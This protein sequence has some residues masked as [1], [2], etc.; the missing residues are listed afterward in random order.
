MSGYWL[1]RTECP[2]REPAPKREVTEV[3]LT[4]RQAAEGLRVPK[5]GL[6]LPSE[7]RKEDNH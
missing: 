1:N 6:L 3:H 5:D 2:G 4:T 7:G